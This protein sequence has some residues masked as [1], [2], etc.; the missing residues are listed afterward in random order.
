M[1]EIS[2]ELESPLVFIN[3]D[4]D[5]HTTKSFVTNTKQTLLIARGWN[6]I[7]R[8]SQLKA[9]NMKT[10]NE[11]LTTDV[12]EENSSLYSDDLSLPSINDEVICETS[13]PSSSLTSNENSSSK[14]ILKKTDAHFDRLTR[15]IQCALN[16][17]H[18]FT[19]LTST[20]K[21]T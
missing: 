20:A 19:N 7:Q 4:D 3:N 14:T 18:T 21:S 15:D 10:S 12:I 13:I 8:R 1:N 16:E 6:R 11:K 5:A 2:E 17:T 9:L